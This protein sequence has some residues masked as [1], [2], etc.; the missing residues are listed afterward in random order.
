MSGLAS[1]SFGGKAM[2]SGA[3]ML[4]KLAPVGVMGC[5]SGGGDAAAVLSVAPTTLEPENGRGVRPRKRRGAK[6]T[7]CGAPHS[8]R[9]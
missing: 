7:P 6:R 9:P 1:V 2:K 8:V 5:S 3:P 4:A